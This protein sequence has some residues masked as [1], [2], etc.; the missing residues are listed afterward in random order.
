MVDFD[1]MAIAGH[2]LNR[3]FAA[4]DRANDAF[5]PTQPQLVTKQALLAEARR[6]LQSAQDTMAR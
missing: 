4:L 3:A 2:D 1:K 6:A 5:L